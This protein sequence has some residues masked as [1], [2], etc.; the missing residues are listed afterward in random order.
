MPPQ[1]QIEQTEQMQ[2]QFAMLAEQAMQEGVGG[3]A[4]E[5]LAQMAMQNPGLLETEVFQMLPPEM[6]E[7]IMTVT[8][9]VGGQGEMEQ[10]PES[11]A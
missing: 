11:R 4:E 5:A 7:R 9:M 8:N 2:E 10:M 1:Q 3:S 6:Q